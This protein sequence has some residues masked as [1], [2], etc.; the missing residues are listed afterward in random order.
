MPNPF[1]YE[2]VRSTTHLLRQD[3]DRRVIKDPL[4][5]GLPTELR[6]TFATLALPLHIPLPGRLTI[7][8]HGERRGSG[9]EPDQNGRGDRE[10]GKQGNLLALCRRWRSW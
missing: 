1:I 2:F 6:R 10:H 7:L 3:L 8:Q 9:E 4:H 5:D